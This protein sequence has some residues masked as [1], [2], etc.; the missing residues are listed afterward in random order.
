MTSEP[1]CVWDIRAKL[2]EGP[3]WA[4]GALWFVDIKQ[5]KLHRYD[6]TTGA[7]RSYD[8]PAE[9][10]FIVA[11]ESGFIVGARG[12]L[13]RFDPQS[14]DFSVLCDVEMDKPGNRLN[15]GA[16]DPSG[17]L[18]F[19]TMDNAEKDPTGS[20]YRFDGHGL[21]I[22]DSGYVITNGPCFSP[23]GRTLY[24]TDTLPG[25]IYAFDVAA[26]GSVSNK[27]AFV[28]IEPG[29]GHPDGP[30]CDAQGNLWTGLYGG[31]AVRKYS[32]QGELLA[33]VKFPVANVTKMAFAG[34][35]A[36][37]ATTAWKGLD[38]A[39][40]KAQPLAGGLFRFAVAGL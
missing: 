33:T 15:D 40:R 20:L 12:A 2:G 28:T 32:P 6:P 27:R 35:G 24:H 4:R 39:A 11:Q 14:G 26:D 19:G 8:A 16:L 13:Y 3:L 37:Y 21:S 31:W 1:T 17:R 10:G 7:K 23:D 9:P 18:W 30:I 38:D 22:I 29:A 5:D 34:D 36:A 25:I